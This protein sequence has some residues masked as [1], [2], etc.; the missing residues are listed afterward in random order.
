MCTVLPARR[1]RLALHILARCGRR[2]G[3]EKRALR[4]CPDAPRLPLVEEL[5]IIVV[6]GLV[7][8]LRLV[9]LDL[10]VRL[11]ARRARGLRA[12]SFCLPVRAIDGLYCIIHILYYSVVGQSTPRIG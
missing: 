9:G 11:R 4:R 10:G 12:V 5:F 8:L 7:V 6:L 1:A 2:G 3:R